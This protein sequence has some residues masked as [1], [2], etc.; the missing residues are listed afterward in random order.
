MEEMKK[1]INDILQR[2]K[3]Y[4]EFLSAGESCKLGGESYKVQAKKE[5]DKFYFQ[6]ALFLEENKMTTEEMLTLLEQETGKKWTL[7]IIKATNI[8][9]VV[10]N[11]ENY[12]DYLVKVGIVAEGEKPIVLCRC[13]ELVKGETEKEGDKQVKIIAQKRLEVLSKNE[14]WTAWYLANQNLIFCA[15]LSTETLNW[16]AGVRNPKQPLI[17]MFE[18]IFFKRNEIHT[19]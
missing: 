14:N 2:Y 11:G 5:K 18:N 17:N 15:E 7:D 4:Q 8:C 16:E 12:Y 9:T 10:S 1:Q 6:L 19:V 3:K 13:R